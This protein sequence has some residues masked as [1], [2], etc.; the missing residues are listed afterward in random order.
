MRPFSGRYAPGSVLNFRK[1]LFFENSFPKLSFAH[2][3][4][5]HAVRRAAA[6][7]LP[8]DGNDD[9]RDDDANDDMIDDDD[10]DV[11]PAG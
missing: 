6:D 3:A 4:F 2:G 10:D 11:L 7:A 1:N 9:D 5:I 8:D